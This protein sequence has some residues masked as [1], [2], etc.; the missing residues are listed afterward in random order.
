MALLMLLLGTLPLGF[1]QLGFVPAA[2]QGVLIPF[3]Y[4]VAGL[5]LVLSCIWAVSLRSSFDAAVFAVFATLELGSAALQLGLAHGWYGI[6]AQDT[7]RVLEL[8]FL[9]YAIVVFFVVVMSI[10]ANVTLT[11]F[12]GLIDISLILS[13][14]AVSTGSQALG[15]A[16]GAAVFA[17]DAV[18]AYLMLGAAAAVFGRKEPPVGGPMFAH[19]ARA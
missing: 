9:T 11:I 18:A 2:A 4:A 3:D 12:F 1:S 7:P 15:Y 13:L 14:F 10:F 8:F 19:R 6:P 16:S 17:F 5:G